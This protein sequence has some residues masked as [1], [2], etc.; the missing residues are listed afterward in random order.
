MTENSHAV[1]EEVES[2][3]NDHK[4]TVCFHDFSSLRGMRA[5]CVKIH[6]V[7]CSFVIKTKVLVCLIMM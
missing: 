1:H 2:R 5:H 6:R 3:S 4:G 7:Q